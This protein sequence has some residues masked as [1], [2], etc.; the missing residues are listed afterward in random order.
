MLRDP[1]T[2]TKGQLGSLTHGFCLSHLW[3]T[4]RGG[5]VYVSMYLYK[6]MLS[7]AFTIVDVQINCIMYFQ[8][9]YSIF[10]SSLGHWTLD[11]G[12]W[13]LDTGQ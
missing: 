12:H 8:Y 11:T 7:T 3:R 5:Y 6:V 2:G 1:A 13:T 4:V 10:Q 9:Y